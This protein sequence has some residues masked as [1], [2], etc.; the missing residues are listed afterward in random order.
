[1]DRVSWEEFLHFE[2]VSTDTVHTE[3]D[4]FSSFL[5]IFWNV[6]EIDLF[7]KVFDLLDLFVMAPLGHARRAEF[8]SLLDIPVLVD[9]LDVVWLVCRNS[10]FDD[11]FLRMLVHSFVKSSCVCF[12]LKLKFKTSIQ[13]VQLLAFDAVL[14]LELLLSLDGLLRSSHHCVKASLIDLVEWV[15]FGFL[16]LA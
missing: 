8:L 11:F 3:E 12:F 14:L 9:C 16:L 2:V 5:D 15:G 13:L 4:G 7:K 1:M 10:H 6:R